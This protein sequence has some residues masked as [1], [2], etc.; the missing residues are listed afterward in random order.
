MGMSYIENEITFEMLLHSSI[1]WK[2]DG[3]LKQL[4]TTVILEIFHAVKFESIGNMRLV[5][6][7]QSWAHALHI[8]LVFCMAFLEV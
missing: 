4:E 7:I 3:I 8:C 1:E 2:I 6:F 5:K